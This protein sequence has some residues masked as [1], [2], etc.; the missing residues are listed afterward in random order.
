MK[1]PQLLY[2]LTFCSKINTLLNKCTNKTIHSSKQQPFN[3]FLFIA[4]N[5]IF[6][7]SSTMFWYNFM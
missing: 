2:F 5:N 4:G 6:V 1:T 7:C 3:E